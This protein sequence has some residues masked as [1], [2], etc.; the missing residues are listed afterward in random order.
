MAAVVPEQTT[1]ARLI[2]FSST[3]NNTARFVEKLGVDAARIP[4]QAKEPRLKAT[5]EYVLVVPTYGG[6][7][8]KRSIPPQV[9]S[10]L[11]DPEN[12]ALLRGVISGG[13]TNFGTTYCIAGD[14]IAAKC[15][16]PLLYKF[17]LMGTSEDVT[18]VS[19]GLDRF[20][21]ARSSTV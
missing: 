20:W 4:L 17:E 16:V 14:K 19:E 15:Q 11:N 21:K 8:G 18:R 13:N 1:S 3:S 10:F 5:Q 6:E 9:V 12:R 7:E 2:F